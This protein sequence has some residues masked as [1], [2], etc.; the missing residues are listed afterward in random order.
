[1]LSAS[2]WSS[3]SVQ[4]GAGPLGLANGWPACGGWGPRC[5]GGS[6]GGAAGTLGLPTEQTRPE[7]VRRGRPLEFRVCVVREGLSI[8]AAAT[9]G[10]GRIGRSHDRGGPCSGK[11]GPPVLWGMRSSRIRRE[12]ILK[13]CRAQPGSRGGGLGRFWSLDKLLVS[14]PRF[15]V[16]YNIRQL[17]LNRKCLVPVHRLWTFLLHVI[18]FPGRLRF[19]S[20]LL[21][22]KDP[23][24]S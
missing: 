15:L 13:L 11:S 14:L 10:R 24:P 22:V 18:A 4:P 9:P 1:M 17:S 2:Q 5:S 23:L 7:A 3:G 6:R 19:P 20:Q 12:D 16:I 8:D 21:V